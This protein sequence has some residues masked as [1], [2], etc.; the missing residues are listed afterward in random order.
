[1]YWETK[2]E[3]NVR[4]LNTIHMLIGRGNYPTELVGRCVREPEGL[5]LDA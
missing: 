5:W 4:V 3:G 2:E 1:M